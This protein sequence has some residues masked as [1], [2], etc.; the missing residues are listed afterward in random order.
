MAQLFRIHQ[1][2][3]PDAPNVVFIHGLGGHPRETWMQNSNDHTT[4]WPTW[5]GEDADCNVW[6]LGYDAAT[7]AWKEPAMHLAD[8][9]VTLMATLLYEREMLDRPLVLVGHSLGGLVIKAGIVDA[10]TLG[11]QRFK[12]LLE[13]IACVVFVGTPHQGSALATVAAA[14]AGLLRTNPQV[15]NMASDDAW[16]KKLNGQFRVLQEKQGFQVAVFFETHGY[17]VGR[18]FFGMSFGTRIIIVDRNSSDPQIPGVVPTPIDGDHLQI[19][20]PLNRGAMIHKALASII[21]TCRSKEDPVSGEKIDASVDGAYEVGDAD[22]FGKFEGHVAS[23]NNVMLSHSTSGEVEPASVPP[24]TTTAVSGPRVVA[25]DRFEAIPSTGAAREIIE[26]GDNNQFAGNEAD[27]KNLATRCAIHAINGEEVEFDI[28]LL[29]TILNCQPSDPLWVPRYEAA[30]I[31]KAESLAAW[32]TALTSPKVYEWWKLYLCRVEDWQC[33]I[34]AFLEWAQFG[35]TIA[36]GHKIDVWRTTAPEL[37]APIYLSPTELARLLTHLDFESTKELCFG[38][39]WRAASD[40]PHDLV[41]KHVIPRILAVLVDHEVAP[42]GQVL[43]L[44]EWHIG[45]G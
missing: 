27:I 6:V 21:S 3:A 4:L 25:S 26:L 12:P 14:G 37:S 33:V 22:V 44:M 2:V 8:Q 30:R 7:S 31:N 39:Y 16:L 29:P 42:E 41:V 36:S 38:A 45:D 17:F 18:K 28:R 23:S 11:D 43:S 1:S 5:I 15:I 13:T 35:R 9:G 10:E 32:M 40:M 19:A 20:K 34:S 24:I